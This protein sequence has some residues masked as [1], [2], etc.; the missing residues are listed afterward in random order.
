MDRAEAILSE[1]VELAEA[2]DEPLLTADASLTLSEL[3][4]HQ[5]RI[6]RNDSSTQRSIILPYSRSFPFSSRPWTSMSAA[7]SA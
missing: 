3:R 5:G 7:S 1:A 4:F 2:A 6:S